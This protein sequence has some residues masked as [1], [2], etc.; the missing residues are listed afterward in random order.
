MTQLKHLLAASILLMGVASS[1]TAARVGPVVLAT[2]PGDD[3]SLG[4]Q[5]TSD[6][7][8]PLGQELLSASIDRVGS[9]LEFIIEVEDVQVPDPARRKTLYEWHFSVDGGDGFVLYGPC[10][11]DPLDMAFYGCTPT[12]VVNPQPRMT[13]FGGPSAVTVAALF[14]ETRDTISIIVPLAAIGARTGSVITDDT[15]DSVEVALRATPDEN[16][17]LTGRGVFIGDNLTITR[18]YKVPRA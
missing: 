9:D 1:A 6:V 7:G 14:D 10:T 8:S 12:D 16:G 11:P 13:L 2:D 15:S 17:S 3:W 5:D 18:A 4:S